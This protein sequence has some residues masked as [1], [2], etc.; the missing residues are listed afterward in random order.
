M[1]GGRAAFWSPL[2]LAVGGAA[3]Q[4]AQPA[5]AANLARLEAAYADFNDAAGAASLIDSDPGRY[6]APGYAGRSRAEWA[7]LYG[8]RRAQLRTGLARLE[9]EGLSATDRRAA[10]LMREAVAESAPTPESLAPSGHCAD[11]QRRDLALRAAEQALYACFT[12]LGNRLSFESATLTRVDA[13]ELLG[14]LP[15]AARREAL[16]RAFVPLWHALNGDDEPDS[17]YRRML[18]QAAQQLE[19]GHSPVGQAART[20]GITAPELEDWL[21][22]ILDAWRQA[23]GSTE[24]EPWDYRFQAEAGVR[25][26]SE[27]IPAARMQELTQRYYLDLG[28]DLTAARVM[29]DLEPRAGKAPLAY[30]DFVLRG[31]SRAGAWQPTIVRVSGSYTRG[32]LGELNEL[33]H[34]NGH[35]AHMLALR[36]RP[37]FMDLGDPVFY[38]AFADVPSWSVYEGA[39]QR[40]YLGREARAADS[41]RALYANVMLDVA[42]ALFDVR[43]LRDPDTD[44]NRLWTELTTH[45]LHILPHPELSWWAVR[46][47]L[48]DAPG[49]MVNYGL[50][51]VITADLRR[52]IAR[53]LGPF[54]AGE[55]RWYA[56][57]CAH[58]LASGEQYPTA[59]L[60]ERFLG[61]RVSPEAL[62]DELRRLGAAGG[63]AQ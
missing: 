43:M 46:V 53:Q 56:W 25:A 50:G 18:R 5:A 3:A 48:V 35:A 58:L 41:L 2:L 55:S 13:L 24:V 15:D 51:S 27:Q 36:T 30:T 37:A 4:A 31:R 59:R 14:S 19:G 44:P 6:T 23:S 60:L 7:Q 54:D 32:G 26:L 63:S 8:S 52:R 12:E 22:R 28:L 62:L 49:Y 45:Y 29:Y 34:E 17:P 16:F 1:R 9:V 40:K 57:L 21:V 10:F 38:E 11:T 33:V 61:R 42:W 20:V 39:W 47:Q